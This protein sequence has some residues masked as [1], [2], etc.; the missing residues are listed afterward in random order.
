MPLAQGGF[1]SRFRWLALVFV[2]LVAVACGRNDADPAVGGADEGAAAPQNAFWRQLQALCPGAAEGQ[3]L[4]APEGDTQI[5]RDARLVVHFWECGDTE[6][7]FPLHVGENRS[8][9]WIFIR[10]ENALELRHDHRHEDGTEESNTWYGASTADEGTAMRQEFVFERD[11]ML[12]GW[13]VGIEPGRRF[14]Y[15]TIRGGEWRHHMEFDLAH[16]VETP[17]RPWG[18]EVRPSQ[19]P[20]PT[21]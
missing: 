4:R 2:I 13:R 17:P 15:G 5:D 3:L 16:D 7:R 18:H 11:G 10:H 14:T 12:V 1:L 6:L 21:R 9:T 20:A 19:R 8:R